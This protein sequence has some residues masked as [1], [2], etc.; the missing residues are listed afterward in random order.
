MKYSNND[1]IDAYLKGELN[2]EEKQQ[3]EKEIDQDKTLAQ[4]LHFHE[5]TQRHI[6]LLEDRKITAQVQAIHQAELK[7]R[8][9]KAL[10]KQIRYWAVAASILLLLALSWW[11]WDS[12][13]ANP[14]TLY[15]E[16]YT[17]YELPFGNRNEQ[18]SQTEAGA[19]YLA[20]EY[21]KA[22]PIMEALLAADTG[23][24]KIQ[25]AL[26]ICKME[27]EQWNQAVPLFEKLIED[28]DVL[29]ADNARWYLALCA[30]K[31]NNSA[32][33]IEHLEILTNIEGAV[34]QDDAAVLLRRM[35]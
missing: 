25:F 26:G 33:A 19:L 23:L 17:A 32:T 4:E 15:A 9:R 16:Y 30:L 1:K 34:F 31:L 28:N 35:K 11:L 14:D 2:E 29:Y 10:V 27:L 18:N 22:A 13:S 12:P 6:E 3:F 7:R 24:S 8:R 5:M 20:G 21:E